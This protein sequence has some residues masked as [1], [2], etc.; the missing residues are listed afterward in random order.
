MSKHGNG[1]DED[2]GE[3]PA[4]KVVG[5]VD[6][7]GTIPIQGH[8]GPGERS[9]GNGDMNKEGAS[10]VEEIEIQ[11]VE[12]VYDLNNFGPH[13][14]GTNEEQHEAEVKD[15]VEDKVATDVGGGGNA[16][17]IIGEQLGNVADLQEEN[18]DPVDACN[19]WIQRESRRI[20]II[21]IPYSPSNCETIAGLIDGIVNGGKD[22]N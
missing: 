15:V 21:E 2:V 8:K 17:S 16:G 18:G 1:P 5:V 20:K 4:D 10:S 6:R 13:E 3:N 7:E 9:R 19:D 12:E 22:G 11:E 14:V